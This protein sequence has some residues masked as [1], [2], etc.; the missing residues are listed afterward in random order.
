M[1]I[2]D[3]QA[4]LDSLKTLKFKE[5]KEFKNLR[6]VID[7]AI[8]RDYRVD[9]STMYSKAKSKIQ[10]LNKQRGIAD[11]YRIGRHYFPNT[12]LNDVIEVIKEK[13]VYYHYCY[14]TNQDV[15]L[16]N[17][18]D[19]SSDYSDGISS[20]KRDP[21]IRLKNRKRVYIEQ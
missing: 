19:Y 13:P 11:L 9:N 6:E 20:D 15:F 18:E 21:S 4:N 16:E 5:N 14:T 1:K 10:C 2:E 12:K 3:I 17:N 7:F 8:V